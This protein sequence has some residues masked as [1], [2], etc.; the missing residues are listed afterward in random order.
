MG[1]EGHKAPEDGSMFS[2]S[3]RSIRKSGRILYAL[4]QFYLPFHNCDLRVLLFDHFDVFGCISA[5]VY[6]VD[7]MIEAGASI[8]EA[9]QKLAKLQEYLGERVACDEYMLARFEDA[10][11]YYSFEEGLL[12]G[13]VSFSFDYITAITEIRSFD[14]RIMHRALLQLAGRTCDDHVFS[15]FR[16]FEMLMELEDDLLSATEDM[17]RG[18]YN[19]FCLAVRLSPEAAPT[20][21]EDFRATIE[22]SLESCLRDLPEPQRDAGRSVLATYRNIVPR[23]VIPMRFH[24]VPASGPQPHR[25]DPA[26]TIS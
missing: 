3:L 10:R 12:R 1:I 4:S 14:F 8:G 25:L 2:V 20:L 5:G 7:E 6:E 23:P 17:D 21:I 16:W 15:W 13:T 18:T 9:F 24:E 19:A 22:R 26:G 11:R